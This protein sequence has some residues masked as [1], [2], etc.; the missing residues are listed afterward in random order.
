MGNIRRRFRNV[1]GPQIAAAR[2]ALGWHQKDL[3]A[4]LQLAG[5]DFSRVTVARIE[6]QMRSVFDFELQVIAHVLGVE[7][8]KLLPPLKQTMADL[9]DLRKGLRE[10]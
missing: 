8:A 7:P 10:G 6:N 5:L 2:E 3:E 4:K 1:V 9:E